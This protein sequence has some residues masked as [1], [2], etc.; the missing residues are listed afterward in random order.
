MSRPW[1]ALNVEGMPTQDYHVNVCVYIVSFLRPLHSKAFDDWC[2]YML[3]CRKSGTLSMLRTCTQNEETVPHCDPSNHTSCRTRIGASWG[4]SG[5][6]EEEEQA[7]IRPAPDP[8]RTATWFPAL[9]SDPTRATT[10]D[11]G[12]GHGQLRSRPPRQSFPRHTGAWSTYACMSWQFF[13]SP[14]VKEQRSSHTVSA[15]E[16]KHTMLE[17]GF[18]HLINWAAL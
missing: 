7:L 9:C 11:Q 8:S 15:Y 10:W 12:R 4:A 14:N 16:H 1:L 6:A 5:C 13:S 3:H 2:W 18:T 17:K